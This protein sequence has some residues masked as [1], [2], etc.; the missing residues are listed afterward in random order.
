MKS[1]K[2][3]ILIVTNLFIG[4]CIFIVGCYYIQEFGKI[5]KDF[6]DKEE[7]LNKEFKNKEEELNKK[8]RLIK[9]IN[10]EIEIKNKLIEIYNFDKYDAS[11][12]SAI[13]LKASDKFDVEWEKIAAKIKVESNF[14]PFIKSIATRIF[15]KEKLERAYGLLQ[16]KPLTAKECTEELNIKWN[17]TSSLYNP[18]MNVFLG[19]YYYRKMEVIFQN[20]FEKAEK[21]YNVGLGGFYKGHS[22][23]RHWLKV[24]LQ[25]KKLKN[26]DFSNEQKQLEKIEFVKLVKSKTKTEE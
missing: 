3:R 1:N 18:V 14:N 24:L 21:S 20:D 19:T 5:N 9:E 13:I 25:Y 17:G 6:K 8:V 15:L 16:L 22:S 23:Q 4:V 10:N 7:E 26:Q 2:F 12:Y 11:I